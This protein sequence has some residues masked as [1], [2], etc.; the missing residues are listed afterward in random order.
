MVT[1][2][3][4]ETIAGIE[5]FSSLFQRVFSES[6]DPEEGQLIAQLVEQMLSTV[7][8]D[9]LLVFVVRELD[10]LVGA[11]FFSRMTFNPP[12]EAFILS[13]VAVSSDRHGQ[14]IG[15]SL[16][17]FGLDYLRENGVELAFT[18]GDPDYYGR[19][20]FQQIEESLIK[21]P[22]AMTQPHGW[23]CQSLSEKEEGNELTPIESR[24]VCVAPLNNPDYW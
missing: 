10:E 19:V 13:P 9:D 14:G 2:A 18:Y 6:E 7:A 5:E 3:R 24:P 11:I 4:Q 20:G 17:N 8:A 12:V 1:Y 23:L 15:Q 16:I 22:V 21:A